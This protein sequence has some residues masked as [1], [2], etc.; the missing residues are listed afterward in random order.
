MPWMEEK[1]IQA[2]ISVYLTSNSIIIRRKNVIRIVYNSIFNKAE[3]INQNNTITQ[4]LKLIDEEYS[5]KRH[6]DLS[7]GRLIPATM[8]LPY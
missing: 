4:L 6:A 2:N 1:L 3:I 5:L 8:S 7:I